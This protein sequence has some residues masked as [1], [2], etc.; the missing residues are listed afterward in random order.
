MKKTGDGPAMLFQ[1][2]TVRSVR[3]RQQ[4]LIIGHEACGVVVAGSCR[5]GQILGSGSDSDSSTQTI[6]QPV[7]SST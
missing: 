5:D 2:P 7:S 3:A 1:M 6:F 4:P